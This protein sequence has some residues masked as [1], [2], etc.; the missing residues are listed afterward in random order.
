MAIKKRIAILE[1][2]I[3][4]KAYM[5]KENEKEYN[6]MM[7]FIRS[8]VRK[9]YYCTAK[10]LE[11]KTIGEDVV[12][13]GIAKF[14]IPG[15][16]EKSIYAIFSDDSDITDDHGTFYVRISK[17]HEW[18]KEYIKKKETTGIDIVCCDNKRYM[19]KGVIMKNN[20]I[21]RKI[22]GNNDNQECVVVEPTCKFKEYG[23]Y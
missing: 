17:K 22:D 4:E 13:L 16:N 18:Y 5:M 3:M 19:I 12:A 9:K 15:K 1:K 23:N 10:E 11:G 7:D 2:F 6:K 20:V 14:L 8:R 21:S